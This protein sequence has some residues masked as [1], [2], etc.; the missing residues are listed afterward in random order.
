MDNSISK[1]DWFAGMALQGLIASN[2][3]D[4]AKGTLQGMT[5]PMFASSLA[6]EYAEEMMRRSDPVNVR[7]VQPDTLISDLG[8]SAKC[9]N[10]LD[11]AGIVTVAHFIAF[12]RKAI[13]TVRGFGDTCQREIE[14]KI[15]HSGYDI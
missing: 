14:S 9:R 4:R 11:K 1:K 12:P 8:L 15:R 7:I 3:Y 10:G 6:Y 5:V 13:D 2:L